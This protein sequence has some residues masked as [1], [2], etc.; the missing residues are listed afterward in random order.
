MILIKWNQLTI[1]LGFY[2]FNSLSICHSVWLLYRL[3]R[4]YCTLF[5]SYILLYFCDGFFSW[6]YYSIFPKSGGSITWKEDGGMRIGK[7][8]Y[9][10]ERCIKATLC[11]CCICFC[12]CSMAIERAYPTI[13]LYWKHSFLSEDFFEIWSLHF[14]IWIIKRPVH[15]DILWEALCCIIEKLWDCVIC[16]I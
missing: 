9:I 5:K 13:L 10:I 7:W 2:I 16:S 8:F 14:L 3:V 11:S 4:V 6:S 15:A 12:Q 1:E